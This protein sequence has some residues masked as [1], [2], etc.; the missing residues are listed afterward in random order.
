LNLDLSIPEA[1]A[2]MESQVSRAV[3]FYNL[4]IYRHDH[5]GIEMFPPGPGA[6]ETLREHGFIESNYWRHYDALY[7]MF[8]RIHASHPNL[9]LQ[10]AAAGNIRLD[11]GTAGAFRE[12]FTSDRA[13][14]PYV[15][16]MLSGMSVFLPPEILV[17]SNGMAWTQE[18]PDLDTTLRGTYALGNTPMLFNFILPKSLETLA[19]EARDKFRHYADIYKNIIRPVLA[20]SRVYHHAPVNESGSVESGD[21]FAR[22]FGSPDRTRAW[23]VIINLAKT[24]SASYTL[25][26]KGLDG[27]K[28]YRVTFNNT[29]K[30]VSMDGTSLLKGRAHYHPS[31]G[32]CL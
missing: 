28:K 20:T 18:Q 25:K 3:D 31:P 6:G 15:Y 10:Q 14:M 11:L 1:A 12:E 21:W 5:N 16:R 23:A 29:G 19:P 27:T 32:P 8:D 2:Y 4:D 17:N 13:R 7:Q 26:P 24:S 30:V 9:I 22:E